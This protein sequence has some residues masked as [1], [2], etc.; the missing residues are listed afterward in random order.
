MAL[1][2][3]YHV[4]IKVEDPETAAAFYREHLNADIVDRR[5]AAESDDEFAVDA[6]VLEIADKRVYLFDQA[7]YEA[8]GLVDEQPL[9]F[10]HFGYVV[11]GGIEDAIAT[12]SDDDV[13]IVMEPTVYGDSRIAFFVAPGGIRI[14]LIEYLD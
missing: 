2:S 13:E 3:F 9:G 1:E 4:A 12:L 11:E 6:V 5:R 7:P 10:L 14:E 8:A